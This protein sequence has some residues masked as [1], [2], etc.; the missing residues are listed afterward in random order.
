M[1]E[2]FNSCFGMMMPWPIVGSFDFVGN[3]SKKKSEGKSHQSRRGA[4]VTCTE[5]EDMQTPFQIHVSAQIRLAV[6]SVC[7]RNGHQDTKD[8]PTLNFTQDDTPGNWEDDIT[9]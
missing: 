5:T 6:S 9:T 3:K 7:Y 8:T 2:F 1:N 4:Y